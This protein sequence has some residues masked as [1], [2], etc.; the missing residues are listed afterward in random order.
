MARFRP[1]C[2]AFVLWFAVCAAQQQPVTSA[3]QTPASAPVPSATQAPQGLNALQGLKVTDIQIKSEAVEHPEWLL[4]S[5]PQKI[6]DPLD[7]YKVRESVQV[8]YNTGRFSEIQVEA[9][10]T[11]PDAVALT[12]DTRENYFI[13][14]LNSEGSTTRPTDSQLITSSKLVL[15]ELFTDDKVKDGIQHMQRTLQ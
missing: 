10:H 12:F 13:G 1:P 5:L 11:A 15:G 2:L 8:L 3:R 6:N 14:S 7:K 9:Q 4:N